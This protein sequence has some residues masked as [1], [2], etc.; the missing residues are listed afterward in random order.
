MPGA[1]SAEGA[2]GA[3]RQRLEDVV[4]GFNR[5]FADVPR[6]KPLDL[7]SQLLDT[8]VVDVRTPEEVAVSRI[9]GSLTAAEF[10]ERREAVRRRRAPV[11][12]YCTVGFRSSH[13]VRKLRADG[14]DAANLEG[15]L[16]AW[17]S[18]PSPL[19]LGLSSSG[20]CGS[21]RACGLLLERQPPD[22]ACI[23][24]VRRRRKRAFRWWKAL[25][26]APPRPSACTCSATT[27]S[28]CRGRGTRRWRRPAPWSR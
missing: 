5:K 20:R 16:L 13:F 2:G 11:V 24:R 8:V 15:S 14:F 4:S 12:A 19:Y 22:P 23:C 1:A 18:I 25:P 10:A 26:R 6:V 3:R 27:L 21:R 17:V 28:S 9:P 7:F